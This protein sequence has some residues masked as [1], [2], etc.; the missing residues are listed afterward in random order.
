[1]SIQ[2]KRRLGRAVAGGSV[3]LAST[4]FASPVWVLIAYALTRCCA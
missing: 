1:M 3:L 2:T 4:V